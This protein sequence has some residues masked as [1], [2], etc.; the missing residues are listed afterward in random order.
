MRDVH[1]YF[2]WVF[3]VIEDA[4]AEEV[5]L[6]FE[7]DTSRTGLI[8]GAIYF[9]DGSRLE[10]SETVK[11]ISGKPTKKRY[12]YQYVRDGI[13]VFRY[14]NALHHPGLS[15]F[16]HHK[17]V[18]AQLVSAIEP[19]LKQVLDEVAGYFTETYSIEPKRRRPKKRASSK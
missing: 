16:P 6:D 2:D 18:G 11:L 9:Y 4:G 12:V 17:H 13:A 15:N 7:P 3:R 19:T 8:E 14:D 5:E 1:Q 10:F